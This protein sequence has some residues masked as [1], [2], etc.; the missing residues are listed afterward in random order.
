MI[1]SAHSQSKKTFLSVVEGLQNKTSVVFLKSIA[2]ESISTKRREDSKESLA[3]NRKILELSHI[4]EKVVPPM[5]LP[6]L[7]DLHIQM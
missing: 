2:G 5:S 4:F 3:T 6:R 7:D 1:A